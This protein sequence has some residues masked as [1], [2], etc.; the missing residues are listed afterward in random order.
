MCDLEFDRASVVA[1]AVGARATSSLAEIL[2]DPAVTAV[3]VATPAS[4]HGTMVRAVSKPTG[5]SWSRSRWPTR[6]SAHVRSPTSREARGL[7]LMCDHTYRFAPAVQRL[8]E[9]IAADAPGALRSAVLVRT[10]HHHGQP[11]VDVFWDL[12]H[13]DLSILTYVLPVSAQPVAVSA[14]SEDRLGLGRAHAGDLTVDLADGSV[15]RVRVDWTRHRRRA[16]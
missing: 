10:N 3:V 14:R 4:T 5:I 6:S 16:P 11:D 13:H 15:A 12:A 2:D 7:T 9:L 8:R 1:G